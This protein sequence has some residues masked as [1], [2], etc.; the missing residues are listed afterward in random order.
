MSLTSITPQQARDLHG[1]GALLIDVREPGEFAREHIPGAQLHPLS[2]L[3][4]LR[5]DTGNAEIVVFMCQSGMRT[6]AAA[7]NLKSAIDCEAYILEG[8]L[9]AWKQAGLPTERKEGASLSLMRQVL[10]T[11]GGVIVLGC[12]LGLLVDPLWHLVS[13][14]AGLGLL[15]A[16]LTGIC[17]L[18]TALSRMPWNAAKPA[19]GVIE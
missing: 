15:S 13:G 16:G 18:A 19:S 14:A 9:S 7:G 5:P 12:A 4:T 10:I 6:G 2:R 17:P 11:A 1:R 8:G 3:K